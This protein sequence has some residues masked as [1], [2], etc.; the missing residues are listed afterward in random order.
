[1]KDKGQR[2]GGGGT[3]DGKQKS[4][5]QEQ[6]N[7]ATKKGTLGQLID[8]VQRT[9]DKEQSRETGDRGRDTKN[10]DARLGTR[11]SRQGTET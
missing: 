9:G 11:D 5:G 6:W 7:R 1:M 4:K 8:R 10:R 3:E 2:T